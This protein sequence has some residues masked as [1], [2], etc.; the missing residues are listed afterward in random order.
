MSSN[1]KRNLLKNDIR[2][3]NKSEDMYSKYNRVVVE[4]KQMKK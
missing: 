2:N 3:K 1:L 4:I